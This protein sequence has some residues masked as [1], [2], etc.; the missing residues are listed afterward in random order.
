MTDDEP[1]KLSLAAENDR[2]EIDKQRAID[3]LAWPTR[4]M[5]ANLL[6]VMRGHGRPSYLPQQI[7][8]LSDLILEASKYSV[9]GP[10]FMEM[11]Q[12]LQSA[13]PDY[14]SERES[15]A[16][17]GTIASGALQF[18]ASRLVEQRA[19]EAAGRREIA[20]GIRERERYIERQ[21]EKYRL[22]AQRIREQQ[23][24]PKKAAKLRTVKPKPHTI[25]PKA[26]PAV[27]DAPTE[28]PQSTAEFMR[29]QKRLRGEDT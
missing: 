4:E 12:A 13:L 18:L 8:N 21:Q 26:A 20:E 3:R 17:E 9:A 5:A 23:R 10:I 25:A 24:K 1:P 7:I 29:A 16:H 19:Q 15:Q 14:F 22:E 2:H 28:K 11:E 6:R 27:Q